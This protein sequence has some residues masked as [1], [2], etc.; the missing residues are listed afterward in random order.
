MATIT[1][2]PPVRLPAWIGRRA[3]RARIAAIE[4]AVPL[5]RGERVLTVAHR[6]DGSPV[7]AT[8][9]AVYH[10][11][12]TG[13]GTWVRLGWEQVGRVDWDEPH[14]LVLTGWT[15]DV[16]ARTLLAVARGEPL[17]TLARER[18]AWTT[19]PAT[20]IPVGGR[21]LARVTARR[22]PGSNRLL[23]MIELGPGVADSAAVR[24][25]LDAAL[26]RLRAD[27]AFG[28]GR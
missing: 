16:A 18:V 11:D 5:A 8:K 1:I 12:P 13:S 22:Q 17:L 20:R 10:Q 2:R 3:L 24:A 14:G 9:L 25:E 21:G 28:P 15:P 7:I 26:T 23:W 4:P 27:L 6:R 19:L